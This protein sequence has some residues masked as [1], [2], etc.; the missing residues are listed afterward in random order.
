MAAALFETATEQL[1]FAMEQARRGAPDTPLA[2]I[3]AGIDIYLQF[4][5]AGSAL[6]PRDKRPRLASL[7]A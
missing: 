4:H 7:S 2:G 3:R 6:D 5:Q 1:V